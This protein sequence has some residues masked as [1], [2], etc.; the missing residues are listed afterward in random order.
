[1]DC[2]HCAKSFH[3]QFHE[4]TLAIPQFHIS[5]FQQTCP[6]C[7][8][9][10]LE[11]AA[12]TPSNPT[13]LPIPRTMIYPRSAAARPI[14]PDVPDPYRQDFLEAILTLP[15]SPK[16]SAGLSRRIIQALLRE[17]AGTKSKDLRDQIEEVLKA[18]ILPS[19]IADDLH[20]SR[21]I[22]NFGA[23]EIKDRTSGEILDVEPGEAEWTLN[24]AEAMLDFYFVEPA[25]AVKRRSEL[26]EK[27]KAAGKPEVAEASTDPAKIP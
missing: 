13:N 22:G 8:K 18:R 6:A 1:M 25:K 21:N 5:V 15:V 14:P 17:K 24:V 10:I 9:Q 2:P 3:P 4:N 20:A 23:H 26:N 16:A 11:L 12:R 7:N 27:L 19:H